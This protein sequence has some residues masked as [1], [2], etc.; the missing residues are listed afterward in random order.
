[1]KGLLYLIAA[2]LLVGCQQEPTESPVS[3]DQAPPNAGAVQTDP[4]ASTATELTPGESDPNAPIPLLEQTLPYGEDATGNLVGFLA[5]PEEA[6]EPLPGIL[7]LHEWWGLNDAIRDVSRR[8]AREGY[9]VL[10]IDFYGGRVATS[11]PEA[12]GLMGEIVAAP[13]QVRNNIR[14]AYD[15]LERYALA[16]RIGS[17]GWDLGGRWSL[18]T[19]LLLPDQLD[20]AVMF[21]G[22]VETDETTLSTLD[23]P[24]LGFFGEQDRSIPL[25]QVQAFRNALGRLGKPAEVRIYS[26]ADHGFFFSEYPSYSPIPANDSWNSTLALFERVLQN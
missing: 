23:M 22:G 10:A 7:V 18:Q 14:Q 11:V 21:Y 16:P 20:A 8:L 12:Q 24:L 26:G 2:S 25:L 17:I 15:Y 4:S 6:A 5:L 19:A 3:P 13:E 9:I 1:V